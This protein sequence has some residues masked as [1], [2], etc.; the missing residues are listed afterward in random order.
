MI[1]WSIHSL[2]SDNY[3]CRSTTITSAG[4]RRP[5]GA[6]EATHPRVP[7]GRR[8]SRSPDG[9]G[10]AGEATEA[11]DHGEGD[12]GNGRG[13]GWSGCEGRGPVVAW[14]AA[15]GAQN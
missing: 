10:R 12:T 8:G 13:S 2:I 6:C 15:F 11:E 7:D 3:F 14:A 1:R 5:D 9:H 4:R